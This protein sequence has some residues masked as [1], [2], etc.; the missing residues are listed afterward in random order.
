[1]RFLCEHTSRVISEREL[2]QTR[3]H[4]SFAR[5][6]NTWPPRVMEAAKARKIYDVPPPVPQKNEIVMP[7]GY[8]EKNGALFQKWIIKDIPPE[9]WLKS[10]RRTIREWVIKCL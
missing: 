4:I 1:M 9:G 2:R 8:E 10:L 5:H 3:K 6:P 7:G